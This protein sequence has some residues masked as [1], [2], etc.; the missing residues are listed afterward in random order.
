MIRNNI[1]GEKNGLYRASIVE[2]VR[3]MIVNKNEDPIVA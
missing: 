1:K 3:P 2:F